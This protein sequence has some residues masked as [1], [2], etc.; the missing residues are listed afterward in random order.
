MRRINGVEFCADIPLPIPLNIMACDKLAMFFILAA[1]FLCVIN[2][3]N[4]VL[5]KEN[6][7]VLSTLVSRH[8]LRD[9]K[10]RDFRMW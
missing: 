7:L 4:V 8:G 9:G 10:G 5:F 3:V 1:E 2:N 6:P